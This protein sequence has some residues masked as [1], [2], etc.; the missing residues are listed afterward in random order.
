MLFAQGT[1]GSTV[2]TGYIDLSIAGMTGRIT[3]MAKEFELFRIVRLHAYSAMSN[4][5]VS[6]YD[7]NVGNKSTGVVHAVA[8]TTMPFSDTTSVGSTFASLAQLPY[9][10]V[11]S[12]E[13]GASVSVGRSV[14][15]T[16]PL[17]WFR[18]TTRNSAAYDSL[19]QGTCYFSTDMD[20]S[21]ATS[22]Y[23]FCVIE[24]IVEFS[25]P[26]EN[27]QQVSLG[28]G[29][30]LPHPLLPF[31]GM[32]TSTDDSKD[33]DRSVSQCSNQSQVVTLSK[34]VLRREETT[35]STIS[36]NKYVHLSHPRDRTN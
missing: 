28:P 21:L 8:F 17:K 22:V 36:L 19:S 13:R 1:S 16:K 31:T 12:G 23:Q 34:P 10:K 7:P 35:S 26:V 6:L 3:E 4:A 24:G 14:L 5:G 27:A 20:S 25:S 33:S 18:T 29:E 30:F 9:F 11:A 2:N 32:Q 15:L